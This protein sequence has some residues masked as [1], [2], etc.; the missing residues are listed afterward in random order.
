M[1]L[2]AWGSTGSGQVGALGE[3]GFRRC[4]V[5]ESRVVG[6]RA[7]RVC[8]SEVCGFHAFRVWVSAGSRAGAPAPASGQVFNVN[9]NG[10]V[11]GFPTL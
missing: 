6:F 3:E 7:G 5:W 11:E 1:V 4:I 8:G 9:Q 2:G 10:L